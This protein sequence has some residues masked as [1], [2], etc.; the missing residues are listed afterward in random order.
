MKWSLLELN[1][2]RDETI[3]L[4]VQLDLKKE[5]QKRDPQILDLSNITVSGIL[6][7]EKN[8]YLLH[9]LAEYTITLPSSRS[10][11]PV[12]VPMKLQV[13]EVFMTEEQF[14]RRDE[15]V[16]A[17]EIILLEK[18]LLDLD[19]SVADNILLAIPLQVL[20]EAERDSESLPKGNDWEVVTEEEHL[21]RQAA[22]ET[23]DPRL[24]KLSELFN[25]EDDNA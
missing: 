23:M 25:E 5:L 18:G 11:E 2:R 15:M 13:D 6:S 10:L 20:T 14:A 16:A 17:E 1:K 4:D 21:A 9:Y 3:D 12:Q 19:E 8:D 22:A 7:V 24:A